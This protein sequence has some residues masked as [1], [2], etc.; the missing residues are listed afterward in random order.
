METKAKFDVN[1][2]CQGLETRV[3]FASIGQ[4]LHGWINDGSCCR[5]NCTE[6]KPGSSQ[7]PSDVTLVAVHARVI[8]GRTLATDGRTLATARCM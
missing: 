7:G 2:N 5:V 6:H 3:F 8:D 1:R 4:T